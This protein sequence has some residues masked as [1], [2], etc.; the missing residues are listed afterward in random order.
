[1]ILAIGIRFAKT[2]SESRFLRG[3][4]RTQTRWLC[5]ES[6]GRSGITRS[7]IKKMQKKNAKER[8]T[9]QRKL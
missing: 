4:L 1:M 2:A 6:R 7:I 8:V 3:N 9:N 5:G